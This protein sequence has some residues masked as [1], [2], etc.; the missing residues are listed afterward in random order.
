MDWRVEAGSWLFCENRAHRGGGHR[1]WGLSG[2]LPGSAWMLTGH[3]RQ[4]G[5][6]RLDSWPTPVSLGQAEVLLRTQ[7]LIRKEL[8]G[9]VVSPFLLPMLLET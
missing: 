7:V 5:D 2:Q 3:L 8:K 1:S 4:P 6:T 9:S